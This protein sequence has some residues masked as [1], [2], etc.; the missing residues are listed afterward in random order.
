MTPGMTQRA[1]T[2][3]GSNLFKVLTCLNFVSWFNPVI[4]FGN[5]AVQ[6]CMSFAMGELQEQPSI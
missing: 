1:G 4:H 6:G 5:I 2:M 3:Q